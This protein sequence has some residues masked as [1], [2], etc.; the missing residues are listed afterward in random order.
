ML[1]ADLKPVFQD[2]FARTAEIALRSAF[3][4]V[5]VDSG[6][7]YTSET[8]W[9]N[10]ARLFCFASHSSWWDP[11]LAIFLCV[12]VFKR[13][14]IGPM[15]EEQFKNYRSLRYVGI[16]GVKPGDGPAVQAHVDAQF[17]NRPDTMLWVTPQGTF[18]PNE[19]SG[20]PFK[21]GLSRWS[22]QEGSIRVPVVAHYHFSSHMRPDVFVRIGKQVTI[23]KDLEA[24]SK[25][26]HRALDAEKKALL[27][28]VYQSSLGSR[29][30]LSG[31][32]KIL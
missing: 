8:G 4:G 10:S 21:S 20:P 27:E 6:G 25:A 22:S 7:A 18:V 29:F 5:Y 30:D 1:T 28:R 26:L 11:M 24:D 9:P 2:G 23:D 32:G 13:R 3:G 14:P 12:R 16:F 15:D 31:W 17:Q 19:L